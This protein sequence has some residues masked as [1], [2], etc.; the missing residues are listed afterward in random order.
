MT[1]SNGHTP[2]W[3]QDAPPMEMHRVIE[4]LH[5]VHGLVAVLNDMDVL[6]ERISEESR[7]L[8]CAE[9]ASVI[10]YDEEKDEL[11]FR[12]V[13][14]E[15]GDRE[16]LKRE[17][18]LKP[19]QGI[20]GVAALEGCA[21]HVA[22][23]EKDPRFYRGADAASRFHTRD[24]LAVPMFERGRLVGVLELVNKIG[25]ESFT[26][27]DRHVME[28]FS[29]LAAS[30]VVSARMIEREIQT[31]RLAAIGHAIAGLTHH[32][33]NILTGLISS[34]ELIEL[35]FQADDTALVKKTWPVLGRGIRRISNFVQDLLLVAKPGKPALRDC[36]VRPVVLEAFETMRDLFNQKKIGLEIECED[37]ALTVRADQDALLRCVMNLIGNAMDAVPEETGRIVAAIR[38]H[39]G[40]Y[41]EIMVTDNGPGIPP[42]VRDKVFDIFFSTKGTRG[43]GLGLACSAKIAR[44]HGGSLNL[45]D[46]DQGACFQLVLPVMKKST[47]QEEL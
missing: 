24:V 33:K 46:S 8:A 31:E 45:L 22:D 40:E 47:L 27:L 41:V 11:C 43:T 12:V 3:L 7:T 44:E 6:L 21:I 39:P 32:I 13:L 17:V 25:D 36:P 1:F 29:A 9:G 4:A 28:M 38:N 37:P 14:G 16:A 20:A 35:A 2:Q 10:L 5:R 18:R 26:D 34:A 23:V 42:A 15:G 19:G 30:T